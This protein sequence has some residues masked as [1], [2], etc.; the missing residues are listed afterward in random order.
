MKKGLAILTIVAIIRSLLMN[1]EILLLDEITAA[2][3]PEMVREV[4]EVVL[5]LA[6]SGITMIVVTHEMEFARAVADRIVFMADGKIV[7]MAKPS[8]FF[9]YPKTERAKQFL[10]TYNY[11]VLYI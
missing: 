11:E 4:L 3:D 9:H 6:K 2:L 8:E 7:E 1:P 5:E 10:N